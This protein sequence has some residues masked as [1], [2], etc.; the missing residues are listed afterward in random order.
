M[1][2]CPSFQNMHAYHHSSHFHI[3]QF[4]FEK[5][6]A[7]RSQRFCKTTRISFSFCPSCINHSDSWRGCRNLWNTADRCITSVCT[8]ASVKQA[9][10]L[11]PSSQERELKAAAYL[12][13]YQKQPVDSPQ[14]TSAFVTS[15]EVCERENSLPTVWCRTIACSIQSSSCAIEWALTSAECQRTRGLDPEVFE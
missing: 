4:V 5:N 3:Q 15:H 10:A 7:L 12:W 14:R 2:V 9:N 6:S 8:N 11:N 1:C 13:S